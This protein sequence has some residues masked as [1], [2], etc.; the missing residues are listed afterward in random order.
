[1]WDVRFCFLKRKTFS[2]LFFLPQILSWILNFAQACFCLCSTQRNAAG[3]RALQCGIS[4]RPHAAFAVGSGGEEAAERRMRGQLHPPPLC[5]SD[6]LGRR[7][8][9][10]ETVVIDECVWKVWF[11]FGGGGK[12][13]KSN[14]QSFQANKLQRPEKGFIYSWKLVWYFELDCLALS[15]GRQLRTEQALLSCAVGQQHHRSH[16]TG[17]CASKPVASHYLPAPESKSE[18]SLPPC[19]WCSLVPIR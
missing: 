2:L 3:G 4:A 11:W 5:A 10:I 7:T 18:G 19:A 13:K 6:V 16:S 17:L 9:S 12:G 15:K 14:R 1:M 8:S